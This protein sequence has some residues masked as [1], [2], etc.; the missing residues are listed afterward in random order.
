MAEHHHGSSAQAPGS[1][2]T[3]LA[4]KL[5]LGSTVYDAVEVALGTVH[6]IDHQ[7][8]MLTIDGRPVGFDQF[9]VPLSSVRRIDG[10]E[11]FLN[12]Q[13]DQDASKPGGKVVFV[14]RPTEHRTSS[15]PSQQFDTTQK[16]L[17]PPR[18]RAPIWNS[19][20]HG[21]RGG[22]YALAGVAATGLAAGAGYYFWRR[23]QR[24][25]ALERAMDFLGDRHPAWWGAL[26]A[27]ALPALYFARSPE[28]LSPEEAR[29]RFRAMERSGWMPMMQPSRTEAFFDT[30][31]DYVDSAS[32]YVPSFAKESPGLSLGVP[33][34]ALAVAVAAL[35]AA[36]RAGGSSKVDHGTRISDVMTRRPQVVRPDATIADAASMM[37][38]LDVGALPVCDGARLIG[39]ITDRDIA[40][41]VAADGRDPLLTL[42]RDVMSAGVNYATE[43]DPVEE[44]ARIMREHRIRRLPVVDERHNLVG[45]VS[46]GDLATDVGDDKLSGQTLEEVSEP[47]RPYRPQA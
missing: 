41:R 21:S 11:V 32:D 37:R 2:G 3:G 19:D 43:T 36:K 27:A 47:S 10:N 38:R 23:M 9:D 24:K 1:S 14:N 29:K 16:A 30:A 44:A 28:S 20:E 25:S 7:R 6:E 39:M 31:S 46:L 4:G 18:N 33:L 45:I 17:P 5:E 15:S 42:V 12:I 26:A 34:A 8:G 22:M 40:L 35:Y 13:L